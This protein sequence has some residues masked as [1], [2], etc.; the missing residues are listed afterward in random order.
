MKT[1]AIRWTSNVS[2]T[3]GI[4]TKLFEKEAAERLAHELNENY[5]DIL[6]QA[7]IPLPRAPDPAAVPGAEPG[8]S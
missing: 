6:H 1:H 2:G 4:G 3:V 7:V 8:S 5:P